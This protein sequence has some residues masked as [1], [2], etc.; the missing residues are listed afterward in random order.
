MCGWA[1][2]GHGQ[3]QKKSAARLMVQRPRH[4]KAKAHGRGTSSEERAE[5]VVGIVGEALL[6]VDAFEAV[7]KHDAVGASER[8]GREGPAPVYST[9]LREYPSPVG[10]SL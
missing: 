9:E 8:G 3:G 6:R 7:P 5:R 2:G 10:Q 1:V 4:T